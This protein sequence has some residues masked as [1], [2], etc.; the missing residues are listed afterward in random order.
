MPFAGDT[1][2]DCDLDR[3]R[4]PLCTRRR[5]RRIM[6]R[7]LSE[8]ERTM[9]EDYVATSSIAIEA[10]PDRVWEVLTDPEAAREFMFGTTVVT[11]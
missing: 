11:D 4:D 9:P 3:V 10:S 1:G 8:Q 2:R 6:G 5:F 7:G